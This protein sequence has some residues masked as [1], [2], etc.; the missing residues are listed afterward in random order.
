VQLLQRRPWTGSD[1]GGVYLHRLCLRPTPLFHP[2]AVGCAPLIG[3][4]AACVEVC[5]CACVV[6]VLVCEHMRTSTC[7]YDPQ[8]EVLAAC[9][10]TSIQLKYGST[11]VRVRVIMLLLYAQ[12]NVC[13]IGH[14]Y[15]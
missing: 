8:N 4:L 11:G 10:T 13:T 6:C 14:V 12:S 3:V 9:I 15:N 1:G 5:V 7:E 2:P